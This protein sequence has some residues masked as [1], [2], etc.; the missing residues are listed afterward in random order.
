MIF[1]AT[2]R[3]TTAPPFHDARAVSGPAMGIL[4]I[5]QRPLSTRGLFHRALRLILIHVMYIFVHTTIDA[6]TKHEC[7]GGVIL[8]RA[9]FAHRRI[10]ALAGRI[11]AACNVQGS[12]VGSVS[13]REPLRFLR[14]TKRRHY[15]VASFIASAYIL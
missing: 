3:T 7:V 6:Q 12:F 15:F 10:Y 9:P 8:R 4:K 14:M 1:P 13:L 5:E 11:E 2:A